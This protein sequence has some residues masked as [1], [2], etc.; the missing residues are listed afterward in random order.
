MKHRKEIRPENKKIQKHPSKFVCIR[1]LVSCTIFNTT[2][3]YVY[4]KICLIKNIL[5]VLNIPI[6][7]AIHCPQL[8]SRFQQLIGSLMS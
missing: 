3:N 2:L 4:K 5:Y 8:V 6:Y 1:I 7:Q